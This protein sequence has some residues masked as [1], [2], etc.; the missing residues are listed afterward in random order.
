[1]VD[2][3]ESQ[4]SSADD[5][6]RVDLQTQLVAKDREIYRLSVLL[7]VG[8]AMSAEM[9]LDRLLL[10][11][12]DQTKEVLSADRCTVFLLDREKRELWSK[13]AH[14]LKKGQEIRFPGHLGLA[15]HVATTGETV[16]IPKAY[17]DPRFNPEIDKKTGYQTKTILCMPM[18]NKLGEIIGV[19]QVLNKEG[20]PFSREDEELLSALAP[21]AAGA[22]ESAQLY[23]E[24]KLTFDS[25]VETL[26]A[27]IDARDPVTAGHSA[28][29]TKYALAIARGMGLSEGEQKILRYAAFL[30]D[31]GKIGV[32]EEVLFKD[33][34]LTD[35]E[36]KHVQSHVD[37][38][39]NI[40]KNIHF[41]K[42]LKTIPEIASYHHEK[43]DGSGYTAGLRGEGIPLGARIIA[44]ADVFDALTSKRNYRDRMPIQEALTILTEGSGK[45]FD[46]MAVK[47][48]MEVGLDEVLKILEGE[49]G[50][51]LKAGDLELFSHYT[52]RRML[53]I[54]EKGLRTE[55]ESRVV[56]RFD[57]YYSHR[58]PEGYTALG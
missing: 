44:V 16:N 49:D 51:E 14:G 19:F 47:A 9:S 53:K 20:G 33:G 10:L 45:H 27:T 11:I 12:M 23:E 40:L 46:P 22:I 37:H 28:R 7:K 4:M 3:K 2:A 55:E 31:Y 30:H 54:M 39:N 32:R 48:L 15:G 38:T 36:F 6:E 29:V 26:A 34:R 50:K 13:V 8:K 18:K 21:Q 35:E 56:E 5:R 43:V 52:L 41:A 1:M 25:F 58:L 57:S 42:E 24:L 17:D